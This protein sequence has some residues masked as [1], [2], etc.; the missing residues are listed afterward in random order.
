MSVQLPQ[1]GPYK[2]YRLVVNK[3]VNLSQFNPSEV[4]MYNSS[5]QS[6]I[7]ASV[8]T[9]QNTPTQLEYMS[10]SNLNASFGNYTTLTVY[11]GTSYTGSTSTTFTD[12]YTGLSKTINGEYYT[13]TFA[14][15]VALTK[16][17]F[18]T[19]NPTLS[20]WA[21]VGSND[22]F[23]TGNVVSQVT[24]YFAT[25]NAGAQVNVATVNT[26][27]YS[28]FRFI[29]QS[30]QSS[31]SPFSLSISNPVFVGPAGAYFNGIAQLGTTY[32]NTISTT[33]TNPAAQTVLGEWIQMQLPSAAVVNVYS[34]ATTCQPVAWF[35]LGSTNGTVWDLLH[36]VSNNYYVNSTSFVYTVTNIQQSG[37]SYYRMVI[38]ECYGTS[39][40]IST[41][42]LYNSSG[43][44]VL[45]YLTTNSTNYAYKPA[46]STSLT[47]PFVLQSSSSYQPYS[48]T[49]LSALFNNDQNTYWLSSNVYKPYTGTSTTYYQ[50]TGTYVSGEYFDI[51]FPQPASFIKYVIMHTTETSKS[52]N[53][54]MILGSTDSVNFTN[55]ISNVQGAYN[56]YPSPLT[57]NAYSISNTVSFS[58][59]RFISNA[60]INNGTL[61]LQKF[62]IITR[63]GSAV[64]NV[65]YNSTTYFTID[66]SVPTGCNPT[67]GG[68]T[69]STYSTSMYY[70]SNTVAGSLQGSFY[71]EY[72]QVSLPTPLASMVRQPSYIR[73]TTNSPGVLPANVWIL[74]SNILSGV[75]NTFSQPTTNGG[76]TS[77]GQN[78]IAFVTNTYVTGNLLIP[79]TNL[80]LP[81]PGTVDVLRTVVTDTQPWTA[82]QGNLN[83]VMIN[84]IELLDNRF[85]RI[86]PYLAPPPVASVYVDPV[87]KINTGSINNVTVPT[88]NGGT[89][90]G[91]TSTNITAPSAKTI[92]GEWIQLTF[93]T[94]QPIGGPVVGYQVS[95][96][97]PVNYWTVAGTND[98]TFG[99]WTE[100][101]TRYTKTTTGNLFQYS[102]QYAL[103]NGGLTYRFYRL[104]G[105]DVY[106]L[107]NTFQVIEFSLLNQY[108]YRINQLFS[109]SSGNSPSAGQLVAPYNGGVYQGANTISANQT[110]E[111]IT[112]QL[113]SASTN[114]YSMNV[115]F[116]NPVQSFSLYGSLN[117]Q[118]W[119]PVNRNSIKT[120]YGTY[121]SNSSSNIVPT[122]Q[123]DQVLTSNTTASGSY[124]GTDS[125]GG[126]AGGWAEIAFPSNVLV[127][128][129]SFTVPAAPG[130]LSPPY[131]QIKSFAVI[132]SNDYS[133]WVTLY[134]ADGTLRKYSTTVTQSL[135]N[136]IPF[137]FYRVVIIAVDQP[138]GYIGINGLSVTMADGSNTGVT[139]NFGEYTYLN[140]TA[141]TVMN[142]PTQYN[143]YGLQI[144][145]SVSVN[146]TVGVSNIVF[147]STRSPSGIVP[148]YPM[149]SNVMVETSYGLNTVGYGS[150][151]VQVSTSGPAH[152]ANTYTINF[153][154]YLN[155]GLPISFSL[156]GSNDSVNYALIDTRSTG[157]TDRT[158]PLSNS[159][160]YQTNSTLRFKTFRLVVNQALQNFT[161]GGTAGI[162]EFYV[163]DYSGTVVTPNLPMTSNVTSGTVQVLQANVYNNNG[164]YQYISQIGGV[165]GEYAVFKF[166]SP[167]LI[168]N[169][170]I[171]AQTMT[172]TV[173]GS[174]RGSTFQPLA[175]FSMTT[176]TSTV[177]INTT[178]YYDSFAIA[179]QTIAANT[180]QAVVYEVTF[181]DILGETRPFL[182]PFCLKTNS[183]GDTGFLNFS[184]LNQFGLSNTIPADLYAV[185]RNIL[186]ISNGQGRARF[187]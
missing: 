84:E 42:A 69:F 161:T 75:G 185:S 50:P 31:A 95:F 23:A 16:Y 116:A 44:S 118:V 164:L 46:V 157:V 177:V 139:Q 147:N 110:G 153:D 159:L 45:P 49:S 106:S 108:G 180:G 79:I 143:Y 144:E 137:T 184:Q 125:T 120:T 24:N 179:V 54:W 85:R 131:G 126:Y 81:G 59:I 3:T 102:M 35:F 148:P 121:S 39:V 186:D 63:S 122:L 149:T 32:S 176:G 103:A 11:S 86:N 171:N 26:Y 60:T 27:T 104:I 76:I 68:N 37:Y 151:Y 107:S 145:N 20:S 65:S 41:L 89:Y 10:L 111:F 138:Y 25:I 1:L 30:G 6:M 78:V 132:A 87:S 82:G 38:S 134:P 61:G 17:V 135:I 90:R 97:N 178:N 123:I 15:Q 127:A 94:N 66:S 21:I 43:T 74:G 187:S 114:I 98:G 80:L 8:T 183:V 47:G 83:T 117:G 128:S 172:G 40:N 19:Q 146:G 156:Y 62:K 182:I 112:L 169:V 158:A 154:Q 48:N 100:L 70:S 152:V 72:T 163:T 93:P 5:G 7:P 141:N 160:T 71:G 36:T 174:L 167:I 55:I 175:T 96:V 22:G 4:I 162:S 14:N 92:T 28:T 52:P 64:P 12:K 181:Y 34:M 168:S 18:Q 33:I 58:R 2:Y 173:L 109:A 99:T 9:N 124:A 140:D 73:I 105:R 91:I 155:A 136:T 129:I 130:I 150:E 101:D 67:Y 29:Y 53:N 57:Y 133:N 13:V 77:T 170:K 51:T 115:S 142:I 88:S 166:P 165:S 113:P 56:G 119:Y